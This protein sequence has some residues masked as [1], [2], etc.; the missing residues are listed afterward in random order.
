MF[1]SKVSPQ[2]YTSSYRET[3]YTCN[4]NVGEE[5]LSGVELCGKNLRRREMLIVLP[6]VNSRKMHRDLVKGHCRFREKA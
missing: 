6:K 3:E 2:T 4:R 1:G 5:D